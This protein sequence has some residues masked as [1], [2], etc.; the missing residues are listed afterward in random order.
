MVHSSDFHFFVMVV[1]KCLL[2][3]LELIGVLMV[4]IPWHG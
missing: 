3:C 1:D 2:F 4:S